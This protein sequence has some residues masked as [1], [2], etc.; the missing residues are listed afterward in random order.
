MNE[1]EL[2]KSILDLIETA[3]NRDEFL[4]QYTAEEVGYAVMVFA[5]GTK[6]EYPN[7]AKQKEELRN[8]QIIQERE[9]S[10]TLKISMMI[11]ELKKMR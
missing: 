6:K 10:D 7:I 4:V 8:W 3:K 5:D 11:W 1:E 2:N 9:L